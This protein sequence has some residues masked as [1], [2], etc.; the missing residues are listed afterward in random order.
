MLVSRAKRRSRAEDL[1][2][3]ETFLT[4]SSAELLFAAVRLLRFDLDLGGGSDP[5]REGLGVTLMEGGQI[6]VENRD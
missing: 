1:A 2:P 3:S 5:S 4:F 6:V